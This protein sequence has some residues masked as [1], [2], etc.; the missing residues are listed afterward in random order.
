LKL[1]E[2]QKKIFI[3]EKSILPNYMKELKALEI[4]RRK[5]LMF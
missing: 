3:K 4:I 2:E 5:V 1:F